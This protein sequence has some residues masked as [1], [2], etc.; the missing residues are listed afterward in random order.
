MEINIFQIIW[1]AYV[2][3][4]V[5]MIATGFIF[6]EPFAMPLWA[7][8]TYGIATAVLICFAVML[9]LTMAGMRHCAPRTW[10]IGWSGIRET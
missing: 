9:L 4:I 8:A 7:W 5:V 3:V 6:F 10:E 1:A 2:I